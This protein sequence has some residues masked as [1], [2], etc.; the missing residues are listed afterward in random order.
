MAEYQLIENDFIKRASDGAIIPHDPRNRDYQE[1]EAWL[2]A[3][4]EPDAYVP[5]PKL[6]PVQTVSMADYEALKAEIMALKARL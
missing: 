1:Y 4:G 6:E 2:E 3:G 5:P